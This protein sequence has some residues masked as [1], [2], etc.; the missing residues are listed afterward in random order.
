[1]HDIGK[2]AL[3][4]QAKDPK[5]YRQLFPD[6]DIETWL[7]PYD[8]ASGGLHLF[9]AAPERLALPR[10]GNLRAWRILFSAVTGHHGSPPEM[11][12]GVS[13]DVLRIEK[14]GSA[15]VEA[16]FAFAQALHSLL[17]IPGELHFSGHR[18]GRKASYLLAGLAVQSDWIGS[19]QEWF[20]YK[21]PS[22][23]LDAYWQETQK[24]AA[25]ALKRAGVLPA[26]PAAALS[27][28]GDLIRVTETPTPMQRQTE[29]VA[30]PGAP[31]LFLIE[32][33]TG[34][35]KTEAALMLANR[36]MQSSS[37]DGLFVAL[38]T[39]A[40]SDAMYTRL[41]RACRRLFASD[42]E[43]S[44]VLAH[45]ARDTHEGFRSTVLPEGR[46][47]RG[48]SQEDTDSE[49]TASA[50]CAA[51]VADDRR[52]V[53]LADLGVGTVDQALLAVLPSR[54]QSLRLIG[55]SR[56]VLV[57]D[58]VH[59]YDPYMQGELQTLLEFQA[60]LGGSAILLSAT[61]PAGQRQALIGAFA[62]GVESEVE[63]GE[64][65]TPVPDCSYPMMTTC[66]RTGV[67]EIPVQPRPG[68][69]RRLP[70]RFV[71]SK[72]AALDEVVQ[73]ARQGRAVLYIRNT[74]DDALDAWRTLHQ[75]GVAA[76]VFHARY[77]LAD[78]Q[79][80]EREV[81]AR[82]DRNS[83]PAA[84]E[85]QVLVATQVV[86]QS[87]DLDFDVMVTDL[88]PIDLLIQ[89]A[90][91][92]RRH[93]RAHRGNWPPPEL[94]V[95]SPVPRDD[96]GDRWFR[97]MFPRAAYVYGNH[98]CLWLTARILEDEGAIQSPEG[99]RELLEAVYGCG[100]EERIPEGLQANY[101]ACLGQSGADRGLARMNVLKLSAGYVR[102]G[103][104]WD[105]DVRTPTR[106][107]DQPQRTLRLARV[108]N[109]VVKPYA[110]T[111]DP[112]RAWRMSE[113]NVSERRVNAERPPGDHAQ[114]CERAKKIWR[115]YDADKT[116]V[117]LQE[118]GDGFVG[119]AANEDGP[120]TLQYHP[121][122]GLTWVA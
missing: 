28:R 50:L 121:K 122:Q 58:E 14:Y 59:A 7:A 89:R 112:Q 51:W 47:E 53:F 55:L 116:L 100:V 5:T 33:E 60:A 119:Q 103:G 68:H 88:A 44:L 40:T 79:T 10:G 65:Y 61:L 118:S 27:Y 32:D 106:L 95:V 94:V 86:E 74:V 11:K 77:A 84:R 31:G 92:L 85:G 15:G 98:A 82:F 75:R 29:T 9:C 25:N 1:M 13:L 120:V 39:M 49:E 34:S 111:D 66:S 18:K 70:V 45:S 52:K 97:N 83:K 87:L 16:A 113:V 21:A 64:E 108:S 35:G 107:V 76:T 43:P 17:E 62:R 3:Q 78:R 67:R 110:D 42:T 4:F 36:V 6:N 90:G 115:T 81:V 30:L 101:H 105:S 22:W 8:H 23:D 96:A 12:A 102:A 91:R 104:T 72:N 37:A 24:C 109:S 19:K 20:P 71:R 46:I 99:L 2:F 114:A 38:P 93:R 69:G 73:A 63:R 26:P 80:I 54:H 41:Q 117:V 56:K 48:Y 57:V